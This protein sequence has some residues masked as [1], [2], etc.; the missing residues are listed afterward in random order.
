MLTPYVLAHDVR[1]ALPPQ[2]TTTTATTTTTTTMEHSVWSSDFNG[3]LVMSYVYSGE[4]ATMTWDLTHTVCA[5]AGAKT[6]GSSSQ[7]GDKVCRY[8]DQDNHV[9][10][11]TCNWGGAAFTHVRG[12]LKG[13]PGYMCSHTNCDHGVTLRGTTSSGGW[14]SND[15]GGRITI[16]TGDYVMCSVT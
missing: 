4:P 2:T 11:D 9:V 12:S 8:S 15:N 1:A 6:P 5:A 10:T 16:R 13:R 3:A 14:Q 7:N